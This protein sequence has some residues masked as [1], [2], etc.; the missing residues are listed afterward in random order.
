MDAFSISVRSRTLPSVAIRVA[1]CALVWKKWLNTPGKACRDFPHHPENAN[2]PNRVAW[3]EIRQEKGEVFQVAWGNTGG[4][5]FMSA[6]VDK[7][8]FPINVDALFLELADAR[9]M[10]ET[11]R[12]RTEMIEDAYIY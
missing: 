8:K 4:R 7:I 3:I 1:I 10:G 11:A 12:S 6:N 5:D 9:I 2:S